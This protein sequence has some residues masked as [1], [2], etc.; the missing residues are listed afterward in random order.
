MKRFIGLIL[1]FALSVRAEMRCLGDGPVPF[2][3]GISPTQSDV[4]FHDTTESVER[5]LFWEGRSEVVYQDPAGTIFR[6]DL[7]RNQDSVVGH[8]SDAFLRVPDPQERFI[9]F[10]TMNQVLDVFSPETLLATAGGTEPAYWNQGKL[11]SLY[12][13]ENPDGEYQRLRYTILDAR[14]GRLTQEACRIRI[15]KQAPYQLG[16]GH[17]YPHA[18]LYQA[19]PKGQNSR[20]A[21]FRIQLAKS[22]GVPQCQLEGIGE[23]TDDILGKVE[24]VVQFGEKNYFLAETDHLTNNVLFD[25]PKGCGY[26][27]LGQKELLFPGYETPVF[28][29]YGRG[30]GLEMYRPDRAEKTALFRGS[31]HSAP[32]ASQLWLRGDDL[33]FAMR[34]GQEQRNYLFSVKLPADQPVVPKR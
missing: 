3:D 30:T 1:L 25:G 10:P 4:T 34:P 22:E 11:Y 31:F 6:H 19:T 20:L 9:Y 27:N 17:R 12:R 7:M 33:W 29:T 14:T 24:N 28:F 23:Y 21:L 2:L 8:A 5:F 26:F 13:M 15:G 18:F 32:K 16:K